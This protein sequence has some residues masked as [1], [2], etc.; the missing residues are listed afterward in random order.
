MRGGIGTLG[1]VEV[2]GGVGPDE[3]AGLGRLAAGPVGVGDKGDK[4]RGR[5]VAQGVE[6][7]GVVWGGAWAIS[8][9]AISSQG[10]GAG[11]G[12]KAGGG[13]EARG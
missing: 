13:A 6:V 4:G 3:E 9:S 7:L 8:A 11:I 5:V 2:E 1:W 12:V 10:R